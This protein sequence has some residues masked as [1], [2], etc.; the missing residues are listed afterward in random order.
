MH[1]A[2]HTHTHAATHPRVTGFNSQLNRARLLG[3]GVSDQPG[4]SQTV[5]TAGHS[6]TSTSR[7][8][9]RP[10]AQAA[11]GENR[12]RPRKRPV[13]LLVGPGEGE[14]ESP[15]RTRT[16]APAA[17]HVLATNA[18]HIP[19]TRRPGAPHARPTPETSA[20]SAGE[21]RCAAALRPAVRG[22]VHGG[23][24]VDG[25]AGAAPC[26]RPVSVRRRSANEVGRVG[27]HARRGGYRSFFVSEKVHLSRQRKLQC[28]QLT[29][30][31]R[32]VER[33]RERMEP[34]RTAIHLRI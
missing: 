24:R 32:P 22:V 7:R 2:T 28:V 3:G 10:A 6:T 4:T 1:A 14:R 15:H 34:P 20:V 18:V 8:V 5:P 30:E 21:T 31:S 27:A 19:S 13:R 17:R 11:K 33:R 9:A 26:V 23:G 16:P 25:C 12:P 29:E